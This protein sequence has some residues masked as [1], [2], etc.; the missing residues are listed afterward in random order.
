MARRPPD[1]CQLALYKK[2][3]LAREASGLNTDPRLDT[4]K[5]R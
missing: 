5:I 2:L 3:V 1:E 4:E